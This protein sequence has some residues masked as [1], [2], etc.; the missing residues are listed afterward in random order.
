VCGFVRNA[1][2]NYNNSTSYALAVGLL[3]Q[4]LAGGPGVQTPWPRDLVAL[5]RQQLTAL[6]TALNQRGFDSRAPDG[7][8]GRPRAAQSEAINAVSDCPLTAIPPWTCCSACWR[9]RRARE[10]LPL[11]LIP[12][13]ISNAERPLR[14]IGLDLLNFGYGS[15]AG[16]REIDLDAV[17]LPVEPNRQ[18]HDVRRQWT[19]AICMCG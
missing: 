9:S 14:G 5:S 13:R 11:K 1:R 3:A 6:Q 12:Q 7:V 4:R 10:L 18:I 17:D 2:L 16:L 15:R 8:M 19:S